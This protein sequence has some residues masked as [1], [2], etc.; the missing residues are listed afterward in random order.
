MIVLGNAV[1]A[2]AAGLIGYSLYSGHLKYPKTIIYR[3]QEQIL[4]HCFYWC[5]H[6]TTWI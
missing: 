1:P 3:D 6:F 4:I 2:I 5:I